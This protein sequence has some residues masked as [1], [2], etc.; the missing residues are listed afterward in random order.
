MLSRSISLIGV[1]IGVTDNMTRIENGLTSNNLSITSR[2]ATH[3][4]PTRRIAP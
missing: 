1:L 3:R 2:M 4:I